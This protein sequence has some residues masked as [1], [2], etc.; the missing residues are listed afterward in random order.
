[1][2]TAN[3]MLAIISL[4]ATAAGLLIA[5]FMSRSITRPIHEVIDLNKKISSGDLTVDIV[6]DRKDEIGDMM[7]N[8]KMMVEQ[9]RKIVGDV[10]SA[11][12]NVASGSEEMASSA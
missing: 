8:V 10:S 12:E 2:N 6:V 4:L 9:L 5:F 7:S 1:M 11:A 3:R